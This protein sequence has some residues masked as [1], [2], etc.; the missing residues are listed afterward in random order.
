MRHIQTSVELKAAEADSEVVISFTATELSYFA[1]MLAYRAVDGNPR[2]A[3]TFDK[4]RALFGDKADGM[5][6]LQKWRPS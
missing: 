6:G 5:P 4:L 1:S 3:V 2:D